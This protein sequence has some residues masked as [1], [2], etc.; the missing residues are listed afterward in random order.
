MLSWSTSS[1]SCVSTKNTASSW[2]KKLALKEIPNAN[3]LRSLQ[4]SASVKFHICLGG[5]AHLLFV[6]EVRLTQTKFLHVLQDDKLHLCHYSR[7]KHMFP[8]NRRLQIQFFWW[9][10]QPHCDEPFIH[11]NMWRDEAFFLAPLWVQ[12]PQHFHLVKNIVRFCQTA[13]SHLGWFS[14]DNLV[15]P[16]VLPDTVPASWFY[17][18]VLL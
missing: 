15:G 1:R 7:S 5:K 17:G 8:E 14:R 11:S 16:Y 13:A 3:L 9:L 2:E 12:H 18:T 4:K 10:H 6:Q